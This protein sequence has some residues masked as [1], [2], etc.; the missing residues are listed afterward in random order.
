M[1]IIADH[2]WITAQRELIWNAAIHKYSTEN[3]Q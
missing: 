3:I 1:N 2:G